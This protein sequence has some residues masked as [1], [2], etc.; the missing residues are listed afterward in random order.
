[1]AINTVMAMKLLDVSTGFKGSPNVHA[2]GLTA[3]NA[4]APSVEVNQHQVEEAIKELASIGTPYA[5][6]LMTQLA[7]S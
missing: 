6:S 3:L 4:Q 2:I 5:M 1:M 7:S